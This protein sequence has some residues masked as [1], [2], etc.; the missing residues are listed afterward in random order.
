M[1]TPRG[2]GSFRFGSFAEYE[3]DEDVEAAEGE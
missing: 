1:F 3:A 2:D